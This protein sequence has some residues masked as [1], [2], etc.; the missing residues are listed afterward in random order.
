MVGAL[1]SGNEGILRQVKGIGAKTAARLVVELKDEAH[2]IG[3][4][5]E[6]SPAI[7]D[8]VSALLALGFTRLEAGKLVEGVVRAKPESGSEELVKRALAASRAR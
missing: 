8:A 4:A 1:I 2:R 3:I 7:R 6:G 5:E